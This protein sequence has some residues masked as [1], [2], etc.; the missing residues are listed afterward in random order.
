MF[1]NSTFSIT[2]YIHL[3]IYDKD[4]NLKDT[5]N[6]NNLVVAS[7]K[8]HLAS[9]LAGIFTGEG[10]AISHVAFGVGTSTPISSNTTLDSQLGSRSSIS[11]M[12]HTAGTQVV[13]ISASYTGYAGTITEIGL[14]NAATSGTMIART[15][16]GGVTIL[17][18]DVIAIVW[19]LN[20]N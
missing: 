15:T 14:F 19:S 5:R 10:A 18:T 7:G 16:F 12:M 13:T 1:F 11:G 17:T 9:R 2:G 20:I 4:G 8:Q 3:E 6:I